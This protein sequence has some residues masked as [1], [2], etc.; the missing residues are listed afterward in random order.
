MRT[1]FMIIPFLLFSLCVQAQTEVLCLNSYTHEIE[2]VEG[3]TNLNSCSADFVW[4][5]ENIC[6]RGNENELVSRINEGEYQ[7]G[8][9]LRVEDAQLMDSHTISFIGVDAKNYFS[10]EFNISRCQD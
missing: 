9:S 6:F 2:R 5:F 7:W 8:Y 10:G 4:G 3:N 1:L